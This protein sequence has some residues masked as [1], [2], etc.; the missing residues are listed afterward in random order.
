MLT[1]SSVEKRLDQLE[2]AG[3]AQSQSG[4]GELWRRHRTP[5]LVVGSQGGEQRVTPASTASQRVEQAGLTRV[6]VATI[7]IDGTSLCRRR[8]RFVAD[9]FHGLMSRRSPAIRS[10]MRHVE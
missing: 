5:R 4:I 2:W 7:A 3:A 6:G 9:L 8:L 10:R 1:S